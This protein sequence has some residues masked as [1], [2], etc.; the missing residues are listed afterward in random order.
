MEDLLDSLSNEI[1][2]P[3]DGLLGGAVLREFYVTL[4][5][6][7]GR[8]SLKPYTT[9][10]HIH[11]QYRR[12]GIELAIASSKGPP[13]TYAIGEIYPGT[14]AARQLD[15]LGIRVGGEVLSVD[16]QPLPPDDPTAADAMLLGAV[17]ETH[18]VGFNKTTL[19]LLVEDLLPLP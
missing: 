16:D 9:R 14:D 12:V 7:Q 3:I 11:D 5:Y 2:R 18:R 13:F 17:G 10:D 1:G 19:T 6:P 8:L 4:G 15:A